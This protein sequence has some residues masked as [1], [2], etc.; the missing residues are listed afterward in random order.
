MNASELLTAA[1]GFAAIY[2]SNAKLCAEQADWDCLINLLANDT[3]H[4]VTL[5]IRQGRVAVSPGG[6]EDSDLRI[7]AP[8][9]TLLDVLQLRLNPNQPYLFGELT[10][11]GDEADFTRVDYVASMI[12]VG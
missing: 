7:A 3:S 8:L 11:L 4:Q 9:Q 6:S 12:C 10:V 5:D 1:E 2:H